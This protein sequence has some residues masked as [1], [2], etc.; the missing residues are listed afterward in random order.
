MPSVENGD[1]TLIGATT[2]NPSFELNNALLSR[3]RVYV[4]KS[5]DT[6]DLIE[7]LKRAL[8]DPERGYAGALSCADEHLQTLAFAADGDARRALNLLELAAGLAESAGLAVIDEALVEELE[9]QSLPSN[10][11]G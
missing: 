7:L 9:V 8:A 4:L 6:D 10:L 5:L 1:I 11:D 2:E 3:A